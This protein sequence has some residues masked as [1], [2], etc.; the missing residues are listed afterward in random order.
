MTLHLVDYFPGLLVILQ[1]AGFFCFLFVQLTFYYVSLTTLK[2]HV[3][4]SE[5]L[6]AIMK[7]EAVDIRMP[8]S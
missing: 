4:I 3:F 7:S 1:E 2:I 5:H 6:D 8:I